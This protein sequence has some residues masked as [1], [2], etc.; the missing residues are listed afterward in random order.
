MVALS[1]NRAVRAHADTGARRPARR[2]VTAWRMTVALP[3]SDLTANTSGR[4]Q[5]FQ[6]LLFF[7]TVIIAALA[8]MNTQF[9]CPN[10]MARNKHGLDKGWPLPFGGLTNETL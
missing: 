1:P 4:E 3:F 6:S 8:P 5:E 9:H 7:S 2:D 10:R